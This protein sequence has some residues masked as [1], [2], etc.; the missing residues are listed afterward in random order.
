MAQTS[1]TVRYFND[2]YLNEEVEKEKASYSETITK[3][4]DT[5]TTEVKY[6]KTNQ[7]EWT[8]SYKG[9]EPVG[10]WISGIQKRD[11]NFTVIYSDDSCAVNFPGIVIKDYFKDIDSIGYVAPKIKYGQTSIN[12][13]I[14]NYVMYPEPA[15]I[16]KIQGPSVIFFTINIEGRVENIQVRKGSNISLDKEA[17]RVIKLIPFTS[18]AML[19]GRPR[20]IC[21]KQKIK[22]KL[23]Q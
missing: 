14:I 1:Q 22:F 23:P 19:N 18:P 3:T 12:T 8:K 15:K 11:Y 13:F 16:K 21:V 9:D 17:V 5:I 6:I 4:S 2:H 7:T 20:N 10:I